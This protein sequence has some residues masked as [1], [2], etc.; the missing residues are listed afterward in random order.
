MSFGVG[1]GSERARNGSCVFVEWNADP[2]QVELYELACERRSFLSTGLSV[3]EL[4]GT[5]GAYAGSDCAEQT[6]AAANAFANNAPG[7]PWTTVDGSAM[8]S[9]VTRN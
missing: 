3:H 2:F 7:R 5:S 6:E 8:S 9:Q 4:A 1:W